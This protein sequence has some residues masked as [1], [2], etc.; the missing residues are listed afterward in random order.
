ML[1]DKDFNGNILL[2]GKHEDACWKV[3]VNKDGLGIMGFQTTIHD[4]ISNLEIDNMSWMLKRVCTKLVKI[5][6]VKEEH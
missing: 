2:I 6:D 3:L 4:I 1:C 5:L